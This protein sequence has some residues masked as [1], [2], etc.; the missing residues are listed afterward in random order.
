MIIKLKKYQKIRIA[1]SSQ[2]YWLMRKILAR[3]NWID[4]EKEHFWVLGLDHANTAQY[5]ELVSLGSVRAVN[6]EPMNVYRWAVMKGCVKAIVIHN[7]PSGYLEPSE[8]DKDITDRLIQVGRILNI[9]LLDHLIISLHGYTSFGDKGLFEELKKSLKWLP[10]YELIERVRAEEKL[11]QDKAIMME[12]ERANVMLALADQE[13]EKALFLAQQEKEQAL[14]IA[15]LD[16]EHDLEY[17]RQKTEELL[18]QAKLE[19][20]A[21]MAIARREKRKMLELAKKEYEASLKIAAKVNLELGLKEGKIEGKKEG[22]LEGEKKGKE[23]GF[24]E[25]KEEG[26]NGNQKPL[27]SFLLPLFS[28]AKVPSP[29]APGPPLRGRSCLPPRGPGGG[30]SRPG[31]WPGCL[32]GSP[33]GGRPSAPR[34]GLPP[35]APGR[36][37]VTGRDHGGGWLKANPAGSPAGLAR[38]ARSGRARRLRRRQRLR[39]LRQPPA[40]PSGATLADVVTKS[41]L[42]RVF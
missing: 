36:R 5:L 19:K 30:R 18:L 41:A 21:A 34:H 10:A 25:G 11:I 14:F 16:H 8:E 35:A 12:Q 1:N 22:L 27:F 23:D 24:V 17:A 13:K 7:H 3:E 4:R 37:A 38:R 15:K 39:H 29:A 40:R 9:E 33:W 6:V 20:Q 32:Q 26:K 2:V 31:R 28:S 42:R